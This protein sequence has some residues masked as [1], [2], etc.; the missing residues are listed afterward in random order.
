MSD[1]QPIN[2]LEYTDSHAEGDQGKI[3]ALELPRDDAV[4]YHDV[5]LHD[6]PASNGIMLKWGC[7]RCGRYFADP[8][9]FEKEPCIPWKDR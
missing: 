5:E 6:L 1:D 2:T 4:D 7:E 8:K 3:P 9:L